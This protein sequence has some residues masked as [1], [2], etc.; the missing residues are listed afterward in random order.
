VLRFSERATADMIQNVNRT[1]KRLIRNEIEEAFFARESVEQIRDRIVSVLDGDVSTV[2]AKRIA[3]TEVTKLTGF[4]GQEAIGQSGLEQKEW[5]STLD[6]TTRD[7][8][9]G[10]NG[11]RVPV[12]SKFRASDGDE[13]EHP[14]SFRSAGNNINCRCAVV[15]VFPMKS[16]SPDEKKAL[17]DKREKQRQPL[18]KSFMESSRKMFTM[19]LDAILTRFDVLAG[20]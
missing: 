16:L 17:W 18:D 11:D 10:L 5:L 4:A 9:A 20:L 13:A 6:R 8:H 15:A 12:G 7:T 19:Q 14:G 1:T 2:R 3:E